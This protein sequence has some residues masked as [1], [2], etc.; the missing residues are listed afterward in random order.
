M[1]ARDMGALERKSITIDALACGCGCLEEMG[2]ISSKTYTAG[3]GRR[4]V[5]K[6]GSSHG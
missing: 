1:T 2:D 4:G 5:D 3:A 6:V